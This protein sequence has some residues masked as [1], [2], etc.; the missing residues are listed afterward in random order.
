MY[1]NGEKP[2]LLKVEDEEGG[3][4]FEIS[5]GLDLFE[6]EIK[7]KE[8]GGEPILLI[9]LITISVGKGIILYRDLNFLPYSPIV[10]TPNTKFFNL[11]LGL[12][13]NRLWKSILQLWNSYCGMQ[14]MLFPMGVKNSTNTFGNGTH[15]LSKNR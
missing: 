1:P 8:F 3:L 10:P 14:N 2:W 12:K 15:F 6:Y 4:R 13:P 9:K 11:F 5:P 7:I